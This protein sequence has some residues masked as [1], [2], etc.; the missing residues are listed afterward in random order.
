[1]AG[2]QPHHVCGRRETGCAASASQGAGRRCAPAAPPPRSAGPRVPQ[3]TAGLQAGGS[4]TYL[5]WAVRETLYSKC[6]DYR[7]VRG[8]S[9]GTGRGLVVS[10]SDAT[11]FVR[12]RVVQA[13]ARPAHPGRRP[14]CSS[15]RA[16]VLPKSLPRSIRNMCCVAV[17]VVGPGWAGRLFPACALWRGCCIAW[18]AV[19][20]LLRHASVAVGVG[21]GLVL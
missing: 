4:G 7:R 18:T 17:A 5:L 8:R 1:M 14:T 3:G 6:V 15:Q 12:V 11:R 10:A 16:L 20:A 21:S 2:C 9:S 19:G 13:R